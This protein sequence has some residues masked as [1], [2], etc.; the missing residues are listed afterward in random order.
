MSENTEIKVHWP[1]N[2]IVEGFP[3]DSQ[4]VLATGVQGDVVFNPETKQWEVVGVTI[5]GKY[6]RFIDAPRR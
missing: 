5:N 4:P 6:H 2:K 3:P 1:A